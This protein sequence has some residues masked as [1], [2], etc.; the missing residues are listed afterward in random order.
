MGN[1]P[2]VTEALALFDVDVIR[3]VTTWLV[4]GRVASEGLIPRRRTTAVEWRLHFSLK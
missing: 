4:D 3:D 1:T 2:H